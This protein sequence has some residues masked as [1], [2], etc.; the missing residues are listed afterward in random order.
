MSTTSITVTESV[1]AASTSPASSTCS[2]TFDPATTINHTKK[3]VDM[4]SNSSFEDETPWLLTPPR[5]V[6]HSPSMVSTTNVIAPEDMSKLSLPSPS[7]TKQDPVMNET[8]IHQQPRFES[9]EIALVPNC[10]SDKLIS[11]AN[12]VANVLAAVVATA[13]VK[14]PISP[15]VA[16]STMQQHRANTPSSTPQTPPQAQ[17]KPGSKK[18]FKKPTP[19]CGN[20]DS[21]QPTNSASLEPTVEI[22]NGVEWVSFVYSNNRNLKRYTCR[23]D[24][25]S[26]HI[27]DM[28]EDFKCANCVYPRANIEREAYHG[29][30][31]AYENE[32][33]QLGWKLAWLNAD[34]IAGKRGLI[35]RAVDSYRN[36]CPSMR[37]RRVARQA[38]LNNGTLRKRKSRDDDEDD[39]SEHQ[40]SYEA[41]ESSSCSQ[42][43]KIPR[44][45]PV[46]DRHP[47]TFTIDDPATSS[48]CRIRI[49]I[50]S[51]D[52][53]E[54]EESFRTQN[55]VYPR[56]LIGN[57]ST[58][59][60]S[61]AKW[62]HENECNILGW[63]LAWLNS[64][65]LAGKKNLLQR[66]LDVYRNKFC[67]HLCPRKNC[68]RVA[69]VAR[70]SCLPSTTLTTPLTVEALAAQNKRYAEMS[71]P[72][73]HTDQMSSSS[74]STDTLDFGDCFDASDLF[75]FD[76]P[77]NNTTPD[78]MI[79]EPM[80]IKLEEEP[81]DYV[82]LEE[83]SSSTSGT[84]PS[85]MPFDPTDD[86]LA[87]ISPF[88]MGYMG[89]S[90]LEQ[91][92]LTNPMS[93]DLGND[94]DT[95]ID[96]TMDTS[97]ADGYAND[98]LLQ[99]MFC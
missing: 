62:Q 11:T 36:R 65:Q 61:H 5:S 51:V 12:S 71:E 95:F 60:G 17:S 28:D 74:S 92:F 98:I 37:S 19:K 87:G 52:M 78:E 99:Q 84:S 20:E 83:N 66:A 88:G 75:S 33:N 47:K 56:A 3:D 94:I 64:R 43:T 89:G 21:D 67:A 40:Q 6:E 2:L 54:I 4:D 18:C 23:T 91:S 41:S 93:K 14:G 55:S 70:I 85:T 8:I 32:C 27:S 34:E 53:N 81:I 30:R 13:A 80:F 58:L 73:K 31:W 63:K 59:P 86:T 39:K 15:I 24:L 29:N 22:R 50:E 26:V 82:S 57:D 45:Q 77:T 79:E 90:L 72:I 48:R 25:D 7:I 76:A 38:K 96:E 16:L 97:M 9:S 1:V 42:D 69:P 68:S 49:N 10:P 35:Q 44:T 46:S